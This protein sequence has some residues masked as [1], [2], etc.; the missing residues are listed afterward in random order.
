M[1]AIDH[2]D[3]AFL[4]DFAVDPVGLN[5]G[6]NRGIG[7]GLVFSGESVVVGIVGITGNNA[8]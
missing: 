8:G 2:S 5:F 7:T 1:S 3:R 6:R 4:A